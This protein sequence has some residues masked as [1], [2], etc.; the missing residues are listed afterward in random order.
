L[1]ALLKLFYSYYSHI[2]LY[3]TERAQG[4][5]AEKEAVF[6][7]ESEHQVDDEECLS[8]GPEDF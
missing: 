2:T 4:A 1:L 6:L 8:G 3:H 7:L 5:E